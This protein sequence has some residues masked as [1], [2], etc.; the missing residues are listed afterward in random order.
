M[1]STFWLDRWEENRIGFHQSEVNENLQRYWPTLPPRSR[2]LV[3]LCGKSRDL[4]WLA[5]QGYDVTGVELSPLAVGAFFEEQGIA[6][7]RAEEETGFAYRAQTQALRIV[8]GDFFVFEAPPFDA[9][10]DRAALIALPQKLRAS[11]TDRCRRLLAQSAAI[12]L[13]T[14]EYDQQQMDGPPYSVSATEVATL[15]GDRLQLTSAEDL[16]EKEPRFKKRGL[17]SLI[18]KTW[19]S[20]HPTN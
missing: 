13:V 16:I 20:P 3:P 10:Y 15:W 7:S 12:L 2:V 6:H 1:R 8:C 5:E 9:L 11:Y 18:E 17:A 4:L 19:L 14:L